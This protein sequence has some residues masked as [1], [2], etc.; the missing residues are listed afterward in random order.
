[1]VGELGGSR[2]IHRW[3][4]THTGPPEAGWARAMWWGSWGA[5]GTCTGAFIHRLRHL[6]QDGLP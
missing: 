3:V 5:A 2:P 1:M 6:K 4:N